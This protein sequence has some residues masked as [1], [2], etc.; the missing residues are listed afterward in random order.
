MCVCCG[1]IEGTAIAAILSLLGKAGHYCLKRKGVN[2]MPERKMLS[3]INNE[4]IDHYQKRTKEHI[5]RV[6]AFGKI[7][8]MD[9][10][11]HDLDKF[12]ELLLIPYILLSW[13]YH[14]KSFKLNKEQNQEIKDA[15]FYHIK[16]N[17]HHPEYWDN[18]VTKDTQEGDNHYVTDASRMPENALKEMVCDWCAM[19]V[20]MGDN[21]M[22][23]FE[24]NK[25]KR[26]KFT[27]EQEKFIAETIDYLWN[28]NNPY[29]QPQQN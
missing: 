22:D 19:S 13:K 15:T 2:L 21:P 20:E 14:D 24:N 4:M 27:P 28:K 17:I 12:S 6:I 26:W 9:L 1:I 16:H 11:G 5:D 3:D 8:D 10:K 7:L 23:W 18:K 29:R 25:N